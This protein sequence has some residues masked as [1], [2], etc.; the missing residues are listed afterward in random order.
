MALHTEVWR[1]INGARTSTGRSRDGRVVRSRAF[2]GLPVSKQKEVNDLVSAAEKENVQEVLGQNLRTLDDVKK[3]SADLGNILTTNFS[4]GRSIIASFEASKNRPAMEFVL[5]R[6]KDA[7]FDYRSVGPVG[8]GS[9]VGGVR[10]P[11]TGEGTYGVDPSMSTLVDQNIWLSPQEATALYSQK[12]I[13]E[14]VINKKSKSIRLNGVKIKNPKYKPDVLKRINENAMKKGFDKAIADATRDSLA[15]G[16]STIFPFFKKDNAITTGLPIPIL[17][18]MGVVKKNCVD[19]F[20]KLDR[21]NIVNIPNCN[22]TARDFFKPQWYY[23]PFLGGEVNGSRVSRI[24]TSPQA[25]YWGTILTYGW[26]ISDFVGYVQS[27]F[28]YRSIRQAI[29]TMIRQMSVISR[30]INVDG[31]LATEGNIMLQDLLK[32]DTVKFRQLSDF[33]PINMD[34]I[35]ELKAINRNFQQVPELFRLI[36]QDFA[37]D[38]NLPEELIWSSERGAFSSGDTTDSAFEKQS[39]GIR[40]MHKDVADDLKSLAMIMVIDSEGLD[41]ELLRDL[42]YT[43]VEFDEPRVTNAKDRADLMEAGAEAVFKLTASGAKMPTAI[44]TVESWG[45]EEFELDEAIH[46]ELLAAQEEKDERDKETH[47][48]EV[49]ATK[50]GAVA[51]KTAKKDGKAGHSYADPLKQKSKEKVG[52]GKRQGVQKAESKKV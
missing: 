3:H 23:V 40:F 4:S 11:V 44:R 17:A 49:E 15:F 33:N 34:V 1:I 30:S 7:G 25:G 21:W 27:G 39:E 37:A 38:A 47:D 5:P 36:R 28:N 9:G 35:G 42:E 14:M 50:A 10:N 32:E 2:K 13:F 51:A 26:G 18:R 24:V 48:A 20:V 29:P 19:Y 45:G 41:R 12:G 6:T 52:Q 43:Y 16:G 31:A 46:R 8:N 22:P